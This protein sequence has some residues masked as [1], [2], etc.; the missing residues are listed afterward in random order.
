MLIVF[1]NCLLEKQNKIEYFVRG[2]HKN[3]SCIYLSQYYSMVGLK[4]IRNILNLLC[5]FTQN[6]HCTK[7]YIKI[8]LDQIC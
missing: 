5:I 3:I 7:K 8:L 6:D 4:V 1:D 2:R